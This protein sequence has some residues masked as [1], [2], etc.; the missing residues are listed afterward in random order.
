MVLRRIPVC[1]AGSRASLGVTMTLI[2]LIALEWR[3]LRRD[4]VFWITTLACVLILGYGLAN[5]Q[6]SARR[7]WT[8]VTENAAAA[9]L[10]NV[11]AARKRAVELRRDGAPLPHGLG[12]REGDP[13]YALGF[14]AAVVQIVCRRPAALA[15]LAA[16]QSDL[17]NDCR[18]IS[19]WYP[20]GESDAYL[21]NPLR[22]LLGRFDVAFVVL[23]L[24]PI[25]VLVIAYDLLSREREL[26]TL[27]LL[28]AQ[29]VSLRRWLA[30]RYG[31]RALLFVGLTL[32]SVAAGLVLVLDRPDG[33]AAVE[34][35]LWFTVTAGYALFWFA[36]AFA[37]SA[38]G[39]GS[40]ENGMALAGLWLLF[41]VV[42]PAALNLALKQFYPAPSR[43]AYIDTVRETTVAVE[44]QKSELLGKYLIDHPDLVPAE[45]SGN[46]D[47]FIQTR[48][49]IA[50]ETARVL[51]PIEAQFRAQI[52]RQQA[53]VEHLRWLSPAILYQHIAYGLTGQDQARHQRFLD[54]AEAHY[55]ALQ[56]F[57]FPRFA[58]DTPE[59]TSYDM[60]PHFDYQE[61]P[62]TDLVAATSTALLGL[63]LPAA[64]LF[65]WGWRRLGGP[66]VVA[67]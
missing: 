43:M 67:R 58:H 55:T 15:A 35:G 50:A 21:E 33:R 45:S 12:E 1:T 17:Y 37:I 40:A 4:G 32:L 59:F 49:A 14:A 60:I 34:L 41:V 10:Q 65:V 5:G 63:G 52:A 47:D 62:V 61:R 54:A 18:Q 11:D 51:E 64:V 24:L 7:Q 56:S 66:G 9:G 25:G 27:P 3:L 19:A 36:C 28:V 48:M 23:T 57:F 6:I 53:H 2:E 13:R 22:L 42:L 44:K 29:S 16:G 26:G 31:V 46:V 20:G 39:R 8:N 30:I 38:R